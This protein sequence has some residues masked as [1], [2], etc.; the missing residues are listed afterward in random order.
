MDAHAYLCIC[1]C[2]CGLCGCLR[3]EAGQE[4]ERV[5]LPCARSLALPFRCAFALFATAAGCG[6]S[7]W[8]R[9]RPHP[10]G[11]LHPCLPLYLHLLT[12]PLPSPFFVLLPIAC[13]RQ[14]GQETRCRRTEG[15]GWQGGRVKPSL[16]DRP[17]V[18]LSAS[19]V[20]HV[21]VCV[22]LS[23][24]VSS[25]PNLSCVRYKAPRPDVSYEGLSLL[26]LGG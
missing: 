17:P 6:M 5:Q 10:T 8:V 1:V 18:S 20:P 14:V 19:V 15:R 4:T 2:V 13:P 9:F 25:S 24:Y 23:T 3:S 26:T 21:C 12:S 16:A 11:M 22:C 7:V